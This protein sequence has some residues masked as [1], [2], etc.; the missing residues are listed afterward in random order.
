MV[1]QKKRDQW[2]DSSVDGN[3]INYSATW[4]D[5]Y[6]KIRK[7][8]NKDIKEVLENIPE[9]EDENFKVDSTKRTKIEEDENGVRVKINPE[10]DIR[11]YIWGVQKNLI[12]EQ[13]FT[14]DS[15]LRETRKVGKKLPPSWMIENIKNKKYRWH[16][17]YLA[18]HKAFLKGEKIKLSGRRTPGNENFSNINRAFGMRC[19]DGSYFS[20]YKVQISQVGREDKR[21]AFSVRCVKSAA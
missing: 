20:C 18:D 17:T 11:E 16:E 19:E 8:G 6:K 13:L 9:L 2:N 7:K 14:Y 4:S 12:W 3:I 10:W 5:S 21:S 15:A 1:Y